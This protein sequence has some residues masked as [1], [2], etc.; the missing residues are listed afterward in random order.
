MPHFRV[1]ALRGV[2]G[3]DAW[4]VTED[5]DLGLRLARFG[6]R[7]GALDSDT[8]EEA[9]ADLR[10]WFGQR[11]R[12]LKGWM[13]T[14]AV[15]TRSPRRLFRELGAA[16]GLS[17]L[18]LMLGAALGGLL[19]PALTVCALWRI[20]A[21]QSLD[22]PTA[23]EGVGEALALALLVCGFQAVAIP[24][25]LALRG[26]GLRRLYPSLPVLPLYYG[27]VSIAAWAALIDLARRPYHWS[28]TEHGL[29]RSSARASGQLRDRLIARKSGG[30]RDVRRLDD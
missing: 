17:A 11:R 15:H 14:L 18:A 19:G 25:V 7:V 24:I 27:L 4:N 20:V 16:R 23:W 2:G 21:G 26:R 28:K 22:P 13:Q 12:W 5:A 1:E 9:P 3:W 29:A 10:I 30:P 6:R 8:Y